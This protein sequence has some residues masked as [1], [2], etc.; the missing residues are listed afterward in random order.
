[1]ESEVYL[2][3]SLRQTYL[4]LSKHTKIIIHTLPS[5]FLAIHFNIILPVPW[6]PKWCSYLKFL[7]QFL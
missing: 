5:Y 2:G 3:V 1:M 7:Y 6:S 4:S